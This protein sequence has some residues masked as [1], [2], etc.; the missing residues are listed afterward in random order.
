MAAI[1]RARSSACRNLSLAVNALEQIP[2]TENGRDSGIKTITK[3]RESVEGIDIDAYEELKVQGAPTG[4]V[5][6]E[7]V[8]DAIERVHAS[9]ILDPRRSVGSCQNNRKTDQYKQPGYSDSKGSRKNEEIPECSILGLAQDAKLVGPILPEP[10][11]RI[12]AYH[13][14]SCLC[15]CVLCV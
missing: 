2:S 8:R 10:M 1:A 9:G 12:D 7:P 15:D 11:D 13:R 4:R 14:C 6:G 3:T 5:F